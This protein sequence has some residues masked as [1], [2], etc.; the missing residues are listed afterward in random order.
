MV[1]IARLCNIHM[2]VILQ[3]TMSLD[4]HGA[5]G[6]GQTFSLH[7]GNH[8]IWRQV[9][10]AASTNLSIK[11][12]QYVFQSILKRM[13]NLDMD[14]IDAHYSTIQ[15]S[16]YFFAR[17]KREINDTWVKMRRF[18]THRWCCW[19]GHRLSLSRSFSGLETGPF[20][21]LRKIFYC[22]CVRNICKA[23][24]E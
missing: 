1:W 19:I 7:K 24:E 18:Y 10:D 14:L 20:N 13:C 23:R 21:M 4:P 17:G 9:S 15:L 16:I 22:A 5:T 6:S 12:V 3:Y 2:K 11:A 8:H